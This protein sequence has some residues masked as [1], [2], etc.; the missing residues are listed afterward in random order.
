MAVNQKVDISTIMRDWSVKEVEEKLTNQQDSE[1]GLNLPLPMLISQVNSALNAQ[2]RAVLSH[3]GPLNLAQWRIMRLVGTGIAE[4]ST[5]VRKV[6]GL[7]KSQFSK[8]LNALIGHGYITTRTFER[9]KRQQ[10]L[11]LTQQG[12]DAL[13]RLLPVLNQRH[14]HLMNAMQPEQRA[15]I[16]GA[17]AALEEAAKK[18]DFETIVKIEEAAE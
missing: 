15:H 7:D 2:A 17:L 5:P 4:T 11:E 13:E 14:E 18:I 6:I 8:E 1:D 10:R 3:F 12:R 16:R 9:D